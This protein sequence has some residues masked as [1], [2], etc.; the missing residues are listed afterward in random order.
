MDIKSYYTYHLKQNYRHRVTHIENVVTLPIQQC[1]VQARCR[2][3]LI[4]YVGELLTMRVKS[5]Y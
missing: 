5:V 2:R 1:S 3:E 4:N